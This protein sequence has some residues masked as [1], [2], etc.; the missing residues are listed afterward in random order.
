MQTKVKSKR[1]PCLALP[2]VDDSPNYLVLPFIIGIL[3]YELYYTVIMR[4]FQEKEKFKKI[5]YSDGYKIFLGVVLSSLFF[6]L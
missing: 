1:Q 4:E 2:R 6:P 5:I 3:T